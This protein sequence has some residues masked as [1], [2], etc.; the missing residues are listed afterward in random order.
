L[1]SHRLDF[2]YQRA[3]LR[4]AEP[5]LGHSALD[6]VAVTSGEMRDM[7]RCKRRPVDRLGAQ[8]PDEC[9][10]DAQRNAAPKW[11]SEQQQRSNDGQRCFRGVRENDWIAEGVQI[12]RGKAE[13]QPE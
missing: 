12:A 13:Q 1:P 11:S 10:E 8:S 3:L 9:T 6:E 4:I 5:R 7:L 2:Q